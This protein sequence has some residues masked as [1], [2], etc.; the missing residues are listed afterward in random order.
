MKPSSI[1]GSSVR[2]HRRPVRVSAGPRRN[3]RPL[4][5]VLGVGGAILASVGAL[6]VGSYVIGSFASVPLQSSAGGIPNAPPGVSYVQVLGQI[7]N[8]S[9]NPPTGACA[10]LN[11]GTLASPRLLTDGAATALCTKA[12]VGGFV[13]ADQ[14]YTME[15]QW[16]SSAA[17]ATEFKLQVSF[18]VTPSANDVSVTSYVNTSAH[19]TL[20]EQAIYALDLTQAGDTSVTAFS[21]LVTEL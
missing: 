19:I 14:M 21:V 17:N 20:A 7:V 9:T 13:A 15:I 12:V 2:H 6:A 18:D 5:V 4:W 3:R 11:L 10:A 1:I 8:G 16:N